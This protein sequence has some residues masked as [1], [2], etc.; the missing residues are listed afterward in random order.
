MSK[1]GPASS[2]VERSLRKNFP[3]EGTAVRSL[4]QDNF[5][6]AIF[7]KGLTE[8]QYMDGF[9]NLATSIRGKYCCAIRL[10]WVKRNVA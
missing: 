7:A 8:I 1:P 10:P 2:V 4:P 5:S 6:V 9:F 3:S